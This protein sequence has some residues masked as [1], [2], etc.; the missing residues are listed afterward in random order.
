MTATVEAL[1]RLLRLKNTGAISEHEFEAEKSKVLG[2]STNGSEQYQ[3]I[4]EGGFWISRRSWIL[5]ALVLAIITGAFGW[6]YFQSDGEGVE[7]VEVTVTGPANARDRP[8]AQNSQI[9]TQLDAGSELSGDWVEGET[10]ANDR[11]LEFEYEGQKL[12]LWE[13]NLEED[14]GEA[15]EKYTSESGISIVEGSDLTKLNGNKQFP[16]VFWGAWGKSGIN[17]AG[18]DD[19][20]PLTIS[21]TEYDDYEMPAQIKSLRTGTSP[22]SIIVT[23]EPTED[24]PYTYP[25]DTDGELFLRIVNNGDIMLREWDDKKDELTKCIVFSQNQP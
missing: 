20:G 1:E 12:Y 25:D 14:G 18:K 6:F 7:I 16:I 2:L 8:T 17:C 4:G 24:S 5:L 10:E 9:V 13:G 15:I 11:W 23:L 22:N 19:I 21:N 3:A